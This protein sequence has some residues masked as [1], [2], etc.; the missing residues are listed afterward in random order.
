MDSILGSV[1]KV[2]G[3]DASYTA[4][5]VDIIMHINMAFS[6]LHNIGAA[7]VDGFSIEDDAALWNDFLEDRKNLDMVKTFI[8]LKVRLVFDPP[9]TSFVI[10]AMEKQLAELEWRLSTMELVFNPYAYGQDPSIAY[11]LEVNAQDG[12]PP[13]ALIGDVGFDEETGDVWR[14][15]E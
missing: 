1:K 12:F 10:A 11:V 3:I 13:E 5:D 14:R 4:F 7:P 9:A 15:V 2:L 8:Y 6:V